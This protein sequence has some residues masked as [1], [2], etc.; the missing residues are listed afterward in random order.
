MSSSSLFFVAAVPNPKRWMLLLILVIRYMYLGH[1]TGANDVDLT[2]P[3]CRISSWT[4][5]GD[6][7]DIIDVCG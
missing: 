5:D 7:Y 1:N 2:D 3:S 4:R 6:F